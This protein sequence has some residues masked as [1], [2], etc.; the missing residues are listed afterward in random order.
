MYGQPEA[1]GYADD[2]YEPFWRVAQ[3]TATPLHVH[4]G[5]ARPASLTGPDARFRIQMRSKLA[6]AEVIVHFIMTGILPRH[7]DL[8]LVSVEGGVGWFAFAAEYLDATWRKHRFSTNSPITVEPST[9][10]DHQ[11]YGTFLEDAPGVQNRNLPGGR[12]IMWSSDYPHSE[13][14]WPDSLEII[15]R[16]MKDVPAAERA[17]IIAGNAIELYGLD[18]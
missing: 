14:T 8:R 13:T 9:Y 16:T 17:R 12:N 2:R 15:E 7:P 18:L 11:V 4:L 10:M 6:M 5:A 3:E 1:D